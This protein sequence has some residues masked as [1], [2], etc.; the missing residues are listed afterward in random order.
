[1][2]SVSGRT[3]QPVTLFGQLRAEARARHYSP[4]TEH[5]YAA[6][7]RRFIHYSGRRHPRALG[8]AEVRAFLDHLVAQGVAASTHHQALCALVF[9]YR[10]VLKL[11]APFVEHLARPRR[12]ERVPL[13]L[14]REEVRRVLASM[15]GVTGLM[16]SLLYGS[17][18]RLKE[19]ARLR[20]KDIDFR[21]GPHLRAKRQGRE[22]SHDVA[23][24]V[25]S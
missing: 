1:M 15:R 20:V 4:A 18:L 11:E 23:P 13:V 10:V 24:D 3:P 17:G 5:C 14:T 12:P 16:A 8:A 6:W 7:V 2:T 22:G 21:H 25:P 19:C 9:L